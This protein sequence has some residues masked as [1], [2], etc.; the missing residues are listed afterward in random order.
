[1]EPHMFSLEGKNLLLTLKRVKFRIGDKKL[2]KIMLC[3]ESSFRCGLR[4]GGE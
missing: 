4:K 1:M 2:G 3:L